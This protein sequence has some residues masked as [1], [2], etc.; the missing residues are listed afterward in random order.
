MLYRAT[1]KTCKA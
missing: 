1:N